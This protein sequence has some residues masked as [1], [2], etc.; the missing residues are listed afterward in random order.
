M[1]GV[2]FDWVVDPECREWADRELPGLKSVLSGSEVCTKIRVLA[3]P[4]LFNS[5][6][7]VHHGPIICY[8]ER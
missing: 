1:S 3:N 6:L 4:R 5:C 8:G 2:A 7:D